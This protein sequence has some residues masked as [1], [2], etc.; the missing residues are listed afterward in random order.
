MSSGYKVVA[1]IFYGLEWQGANL[2]AQK[3]PKEERVTD[4][5]SET[6]PW[7]PRSEPGTGRFLPIC[8]IAVAFLTCCVY[9]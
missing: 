9:V 1:G 3:K 7:K 8:G 5:S 4:H 6:K 2:C